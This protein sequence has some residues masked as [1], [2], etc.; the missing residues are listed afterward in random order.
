MGTNRRGREFKDA[1]ALFLSENIGNT[2]FR[3]LLF[4][5]RFYIRGQIKVY[6]I[7]KLSWILYGIVETTEN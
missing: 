1:M 7:R 6:Y 2:W 3:L 5:Y 4:F